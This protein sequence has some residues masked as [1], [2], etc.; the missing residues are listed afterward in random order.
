MKQYFGLHHNVNGS[1]TLVL[2]FCNDNYEWEQWEHE[3]NVMDIVKA[4]RE[5]WGE[6][7]AEVELGDIIDWAAEDHYFYADDSDDTHEREGWSWMGR[8]IYDKTS[9]LTT[10]VNYCNYYIIRN[11]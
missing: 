3:I 5:A 1:D 7:E 8:P 4:M 10:L 2:I 11:R 9:A 6:P